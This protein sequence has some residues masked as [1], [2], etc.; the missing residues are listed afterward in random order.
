MAKTKTRSA[1]QSP[2]VK[3][4]PPG[5]RPAKISHKSYKTRGGSIAGGHM[6]GTMGKC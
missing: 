2:A 4:T 6:A 5:A 1:K 3:H